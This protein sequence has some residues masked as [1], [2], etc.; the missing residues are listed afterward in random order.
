MRADESLCAVIF[1]P[2]VTAFRPQLGLPESHPLY[3]WILSV[4]IVIFGGAYFRLG[5]SGRADR[6]F[7]AVGAAGKATFAL[8][9]IALALTGDLPPNAAGVGLPD[10]AIAAIFTGWLLRTTR[11]SPVEET[12]V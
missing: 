2:P 4:W 11:P 5:L 12:T 9:L 1:A 8:I 3:L 10:L 6:T 7:L